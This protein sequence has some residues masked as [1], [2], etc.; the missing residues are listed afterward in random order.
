M[1]KNIHDQINKG[2]YNIS[3][4]QFYLDPEV[5]DIH[6]ELIA[7]SNTVSYH[8]FMDIINKNKYFD[9]QTL[10]TIKLVFDQ[11]DLTTDFARNSFI[12]A[13]AKG[14]SANFVGMSNT[15]LA[16]SGYA[17]FTEDIKVSYSL[18]LNG[19]NSEI[20][21]ERLVDLNTFIL[22]IETSEYY[23]KEFI[24]RMNQNTTTST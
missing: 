12:H 1:S 3:K 17:E 9:S 7:K 14:G 15:A 19:M 5:I 6:V 23:V 24:E 20:F 18:I 21:S 10:E 13:G 8:K 2:T 11:V 16:V 22:A 4:D